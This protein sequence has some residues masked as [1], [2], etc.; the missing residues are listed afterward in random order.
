MQRKF[1]TFKA[2]R[3][4]SYKIRLLRFKRLGRYPILVPIAT[5]VVLTV[6]SL[7][8]FLNINHGSPEFKPITSYIVIISH[9][10]VQETIPTDEPTV[11]SL[12]KKLG[13]TLNQGD[14]VEPSLSTQINE[15]NFRINIYRA[16]PVEIIEGTTK[17]FTFSAA[18][19]ARSI[20]QQAGVTI[21]PEDYVNLVPTQNFI[22][23]G[24]VGEQV[25]INPATP[26]SV[27]FY[28]T[29]TTLRTH[30]KTVGDLLA[31]NNIKLRQG[32]S[33]QPSQTTPIT[34][35]MQV[36]LIHKGTQIKTVQQAIPAPVQIVQDSSLTIGT[37]AVRQAGVAGSELVT[38]ELSLQNGVV[39]GQTPIQT[40]VSTAPVTQIVAEGTASLGGALQEW[41]YELRMCESSGNYADDT[42][43]GYYGA[44]QFSLGT[45]DKY[46]TGYSTANLAPPEVQDTTIIKNTEASSGGLA[47]Q[48]PGCYAKE[49]LSAFPPSD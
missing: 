34:P 31:T 49:G 35:G 48:N 21:Y 37:S 6:I 11:G 45:W 27:N 14:V 47:T 9:D 8:L 28:G 18:T 16:V 10:H 24:A 2:R 5:F 19:T 33:V 40:V 7:G 42:G 46:N 32:D 12:L 3:Y 17:T 1:H 30:T 43:N 41:L 36:F 20:V 44:Y 39:V 22:L 29:P 38:Y 4:R 25:V 13:I 23:G 26:V 15:D